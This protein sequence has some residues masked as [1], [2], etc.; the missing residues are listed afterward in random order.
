MI[1]RGR[2]IIVS[3]VFIIVVAICI[4]FC[5]LLLDNN[6]IEEEDYPRVNIYKYEI[7]SNE[8]KYYLDKLD[9][10]KIALKEAIP[11]RCKS[12][13]CTYAKSLFAMNNIK[14]DKVLI[15]DDD[16]L[17]IYDYIKNKKTII[18]DIKK[19]TTADFI[20]NG[21]YIL[22]ISE[23]TYYAYNIKKKTLSSPF[24]TDLLVTKDNVIE[25]V[26]SNGLITIDHG[27]YGIVNLDTGNNMFDNVYDYIECNNKVCLFEYEG[28]STLFNANNPQGDSIIDDAKSVL[29]LDEDYVI[30]NKDK[31]SYL[32]DIKTSTE[33]NIGFID[34]K[35]IGID[36]SKDQIMVDTTKNSECY[37]WNLDTDTKNKVDCTIKDIVTDIYVSSA[38]KSNFTVTYGNNSKNTYE[39]KVLNNKLYDGNGTFYD[40]ISIN[41]AYNDI[42]DEL[43]VINISKDE[44]YTFLNELSSR[45]GLDDFERLSFINRWLPTL[46]KNDQSTVSISFS[47]KK[48]NIIDI[49]II[50]EMNSYETIFMRVQNG[51]SNSV[52]KL[53]EL[54]IPKL[55]RRTSS[56]FAIS[57]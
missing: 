36:N 24:R 55:D 43:K 34:E 40:K 46:I 3:S 17:L 7:S 35:V 27:K 14:D 9:V 22:I 20:D 4:V 32:Y 15:I 28:K 45:I 13:D 57:G 56:V 5:F 21:N 19:I 51:S 8:Y 52:T 41:S 16:S 54:N 12:D 33:K 30:Y 42:G 38:S 11:Y 23:D 48:K 10:N 1:N 39:L 18:D 49:H 50:T 25:K 6:E 31:S 26:F 29:F 44:A 47:N 2:Y 53:D 37:R